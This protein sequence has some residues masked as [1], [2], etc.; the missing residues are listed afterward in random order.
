M[1]QSV[2]QCCIMAKN[3]LTRHISKD[4]TPLCFSCNHGNRSKT[5]ARAHT[6][7]KTGAD[8]HQGIPFS[9][10]KLHFTVFRGRGEEWRL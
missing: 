7:I 3:A 8:V 6:Q 4:H 5:H 1:D 10:A 2:Y 9:S